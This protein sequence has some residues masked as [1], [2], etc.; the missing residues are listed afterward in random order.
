MQ[1]K[2]AQFVHREGKNLF[3]SP[4]DQ[5]WCQAACVKTFASGS[6]W[7]IYDHYLIP[8]DPALAMNYDIAGPEEQED[9]MRAYKEQ[10]S[11]VL[12]LETSMWNRFAQS[13][14]ENLSVFEELSGAAPVCTVPEENYDFVTKKTF[15]IRGYD[16]LGRCA[17]HMISI[18]EGTKFTWVREGLALDEQY[19][20]GRG[21]GKLPVWHMS[22]F[23]NAQIGIELDLPTR[24]LSLVLESLKED[25]KL[26]EDTTPYEAH[27]VC[28]RCG[29]Q[30]SV[31]P[32]IYPDGL[33]YPYPA[34]FSV[35]GTEYLIDDWLCDGCYEV[36]FGGR[37]HTWAFQIGDDTFIPPADRFSQIDD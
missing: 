7:D 20:E 30:M 12:L 26:P 36:V 3:I 17:G 18:P 13:D 37:Q 24:Y 34:L 14:V 23:R 19:D 29:A 16:D 27:A 11:G 33:D 22:S 2:K 1:E 32:C 9:G 4:A 28:R 6:V 21:I 25:V 15:S 31:P 5:H 35:E 8:Y 10:K